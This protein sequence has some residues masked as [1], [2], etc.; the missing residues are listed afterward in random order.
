VRQQLLSAA[1]ICG[2]SYNP[3]R[4][5]PGDGAPGGDAPVDGL[6]DDDDDDNDGVLDTDDNCPLV[7]NPDQHDEDGD[8]RGDACDP[9][10]MFATGDDDDQDGDGIADACDPN[11]MTPGD[12]L[13]LFDGF[14][15]DGNLPSAWTQ[16]GGF[17]GDWGVAQDALQLDTHVAP[18]QLRFDA[19]GARTTVHFVATHSLPG[20]GSVPALGAIVDSDP[21]HANLLSCTVLT[22]QANQNLL[23][24]RCIAD[25]CSTF[26]ASGS[27]AVQATVRVIAISEPD[28]LDCRF[29]TGASTAF[30]S[31]GVT[32]TRSGTGIA[33]QN[34]RVAIPFIAVYRSP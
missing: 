14:G 16:I 8:T 15:V 24:V 29:T 34:L 23:S 18:R 27:S 3:A 11:P 19:G 28:R 6:V 31:T 33:V 32:P 20:G 26:G 1:V 5:V 17:P 30:E 12:E 4:G 13:V 10:P 25:S 2:C 22:E 7:A 9:C 21:T